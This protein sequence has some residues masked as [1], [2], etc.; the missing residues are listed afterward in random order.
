MPKKWIWFEKGTLESISRVFSCPSQLDPSSCQNST[1]KSYTHVKT[2]PRDGR[3]NKIL[4]EQK[5]QCAGLAQENGFC[6]EFLYDRHTHL[7]IAII[8]MAAPTFSPWC[9]N[10]A[11]VQVMEVVVAVLLSLLPHVHDDA[12]EEEVRLPP[13]LLCNKA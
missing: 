6:L 12:N 10:Q 2:L 9:W 7:I 11:Q 1:S 3:A 13:F 5:S 8:R 4:D